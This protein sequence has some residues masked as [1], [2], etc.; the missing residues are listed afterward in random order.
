MI[1]ETAFCN[2]DGGIVLV[3]LNR[4][5]HEI[6]VNVRLGEQMTQLVIGTDTIGTVEIV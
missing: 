4:T 2:P 1:D 5:A 3:L 6:Q